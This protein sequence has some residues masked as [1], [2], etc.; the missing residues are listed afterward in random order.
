MEELLPPNILENINNDEDRTQLFNKLGKVSYIKNGKRYDG[1]IDLDGSTILYHLIGSETGS[2]AG[3]ATGG[4]EAICTFANASIW[5]KAIDDNFVG[6]SVLTSLPPDIP[7]GG[8]GNDSS[9][10]D[11]AL[12]IGDLPFPPQPAGFNQRRLAQACSITE[13]HDDD[14][15]EGLD[16]S[17]DNGD[18]DF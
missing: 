7:A 15:K 8:V 1:A 6:K 13:R 16:F 10:V 4:G 3:V 17:S 18:F 2:A 5:V 12:G 14:P 11:A 9:V